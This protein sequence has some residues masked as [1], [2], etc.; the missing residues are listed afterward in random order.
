MNKDNIIA[1]VAVEAR[2]TKKDAATA[3]D[4]VFESI[5]NALANGEEVKIAGFGSFDVRVHKSRVGMNPITKESI[6]IPEMKAI[7]FH[8]GKQAKEKVN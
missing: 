5:L 4:A 2:L 1:D 6:Q 3:V 7:A 8:A